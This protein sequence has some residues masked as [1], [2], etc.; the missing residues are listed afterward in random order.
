[1]RGAI[2]EVFEHDILDVSKI[3]EGRV[4]LSAESFNASEPVAEVLSLLK[5]LALS[6]HIAVKNRVAGDLVLFAD[7]MR[8]KQILYNLVSNAV[9]FTPE[10]GSVTL[11]AS[12]ESDGVTISVTD[13]GVGI[14]AEERAAIFDKFY[15]VGTT[16]AGVKE[17]SGLGLAI[18]RGLVQMHG[19]NIW[20]DSTV[21][22]GSRFTFSLPSQVLSPLSACRTGS[23][24]TAPA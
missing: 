12:S 5:P 17:G 16:T 13:T 3:E 1:M 23:R 14:P 9:K 22:K 10:G 6:K 19:G 8:F 24:A 18:T 7:H 11:E 4:E 2:D 20:V 21:G 15:Q